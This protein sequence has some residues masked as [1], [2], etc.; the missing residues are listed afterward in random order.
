MYP[1]YLDTN[2]NFYDWCEA[3][4]YDGDDEQ[5]YQEEVFKRGAHV[6]FHI[7]KDDETFALVTAYQS[8]DNG[9]EEINI[10]R[11]GLKRVE[12]QV[13]TTVVVYE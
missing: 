3:N 10:Q 13:T 7:P 5:D 12:K 4:G 1:I 2:N 9:R 8:Y 11:E 6:S